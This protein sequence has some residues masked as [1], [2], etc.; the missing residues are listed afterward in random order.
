LGIDITS[1]EQPARL[2]HARL[3]IHTDHIGLRMTIREQFIYGVKELNSDNWQQLEP[4]EVPSLTDWAPGLIAH[5]GDE[6]SLR[7]AKF[8]AL[9][10]RAL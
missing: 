3:P 6:S 1:L 2:V 4:V 7:W 9:S 10:M 8:T 5:G